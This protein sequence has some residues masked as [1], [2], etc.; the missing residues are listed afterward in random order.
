VD[1]ELERGAS[2]RAEEIFFKAIGVLPAL[3]HLDLQLNLFL[4]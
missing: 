4:K 1:R 3:S 2:K